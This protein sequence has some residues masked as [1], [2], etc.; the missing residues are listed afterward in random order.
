M[1]LYKL[2]RGKKKMKYIIDSIVNLIIYNEPSKEKETMI[3]IDGFDELAIYEQ[4]A[5][6]ISNIVKEKGLTI[7]IRLAKNKYNNFK[8]SEDI[9]TTILQSMEQHNW[10]AT[11]ASITYYRNLHKS[12][13]V[14]LMG[15]EDEEDRGGLA[16]CYSITPDTI[17]KTLNQQYHI[18]F[19]NE[20]F[21]NEDNEIVDNLS[22]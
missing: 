8:N 12:D 3:R 1:K 7:N 2:K 13:V 14:L 11:E 21:T 19:V 15:T 10:V 18:L 9:N 16:N 17:V 4:V 5:T 20:F 22:A 6:K